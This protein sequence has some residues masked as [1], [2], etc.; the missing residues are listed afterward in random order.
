MISVNRVCMR[1]TFHSISFLFVYCKS[2]RNN[3]ISISKF[4]LD[5]KN[6]ICWIANIFA[7]PYVILHPLYLSFANSCKVDLPNSPKFPYA[8]NLY[9]MVF[10]TPCTAIEG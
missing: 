4:L 7:N 10:S 6:E 1:I 5:K 9:H 3:T 2:T 8:K